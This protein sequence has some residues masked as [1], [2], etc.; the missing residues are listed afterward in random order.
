M[1]AMIAGVLAAAVAVLTWSGPQTHPDFSGRWT[2]EPVT[3]PAS[4]AAPDVRGDMGSGWAPAITIAQNAERLTVEQ[5]TFTR[6]DMQPPVRFTY[7]L[8]GS[9]TRNT[10]MMGRGIQAQSSRAEWAG[11]ALKITTVF[12]N[13]NPA[14]GIPPTTEV[15]Q[16]LMLESPTSLVVEAARGAST[17]R[18]VYRKN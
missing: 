6:Y 13:P 12:T 8:D 18:T 15:V 1:P 2:V 14:P 7:A 9:E 17:T 5:S 10:M 11:Q 4:G 3:A 16:T